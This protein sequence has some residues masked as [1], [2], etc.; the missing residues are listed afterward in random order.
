ME[1]SWIYA[2]YFSET[3]YTVTKIDQCDCSSQNNMYIDDV[4]NINTL[5]NMSTIIQPINEV[6][7]WNI[8]SPA[9]DIKF[10]E[11]NDKILYHIIQ[12]RF[13]AYPGQQF[14]VALIAFGQAGYP[15]PTKI[16]GRS[17]IIITEMLH[18]VL[19]H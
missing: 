18:I 11:N 2:D 19:I 1:D 3:V 17:K 8:S 12:K 10:C 9:K 4:L 13:N 6:S 7:V 5:M 14:N 16:F 15:V